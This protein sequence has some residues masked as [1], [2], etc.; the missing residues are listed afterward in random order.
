MDKLFEYSVESA[1]SLAVFYLFYWIFL[2]KSTHFRLNRF[3]LMFSV[4]SSVIL[5]ALA[6]RLNMPGTGALNLAIDFS[7]TEAPSSAASALVQTSNP[8]ARYSF[9]ETI[10]LIYVVGA[11]II[12][13]RLAYQA[14]YLHAISRLSKTTVHQGF[15]IIS[16]DTDMIPFSY[17]NRIFIPADRINEHSLD[18]VITHEKSHLA[19][20][21]YLD[22]FIVQVVTVL[23]WFNPFIWLF[24]KSIKEVHEYLADEAVL[25]S[26]KDMGNYQAILVNEALGGPVFILTNQLNKSLIKKRI[27]MMKNLKSPKITQLKALLIVP[28]LA[29]L[30]LA[31]ANPSLI[32]QTGGD[33][34]TIKGNVSSRQ[35]GNPLPAIL[36]L[37]K[38]TTTGTITDAQGNY[39]IVVNSTEDILVVTHVGYRSQEVPVGKNIKIDIM[40]EPDILTIDFNSGNKF[41]LRKKE[42]ESNELTGSYVI[43]EELPTYPG[44]TVALSKFISQ[45]IQYP[46]DAKKAR[47]QGTVH[48]TYIIDEKGEIKSA[49]VI[50]GLGLEIDKEALRVT[51]LIKGWNPASQNGKPIATTVIMP[52][53][54]RLN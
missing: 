19:Q 38:G 27:V 48:V 45:N 2:R 14:I 53:E 41:E 24:E 13:A 50:R 43:T 32:S 37:I 35:S 49:K 30:L 12:L 20:G 39:E 29:G 11:A 33:G 3:I 21:H 28:L 18:S 42:K 36:V 52:I 46:D 8:V 10:G 6:N 34:I 5:P 16:L 23:Q 51:N 54:F 7:T 22:L 15:K 1:I 9:L 25:E 4:I 31:F 26:G 44:G 47:V 40:L 17:F